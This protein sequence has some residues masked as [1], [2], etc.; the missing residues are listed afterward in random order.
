MEIDIRLFSDLDPIALYAAL[1]A[2]SVLIWDIVKWVRRGPQLK[3]K[4]SSHM[5]FIG[6]YD[7]TDKLFVAINVTNVGSQPT[8]IRTVGL[9]GYSNRWSW[10]RNKPD[11]AAVISHDS[12]SYPLPYVLN[13]GGEFSSYCDQEALAVC[14]I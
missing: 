1:V 2:T 11:K 7:D 10:F 3:G 8:T 14:R 5:L 9:L 13:V 6:G 4:A 12:P